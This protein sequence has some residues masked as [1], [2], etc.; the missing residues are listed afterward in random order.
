MLGSCLIP[1]LE[2]IVHSVICSFIDFKY[3]GCLYVT[4]KGSKN[5]IWSQFEKCS[6]WGN[7][8][9]AS[10]A[11]YQSEGLSLLNIEIETQ[12]WNSSLIKF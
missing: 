1:F 12:S 9:F 10:I 7:R 11:S 4:G 5:E 3:I 2:C 6:N 8:A